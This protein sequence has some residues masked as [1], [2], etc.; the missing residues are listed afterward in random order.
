MENV[1]LGQFYD[2]RLFARFIYENNGHGIRSQCLT[3]KRLSPFTLGDAPVAR[4]LN[5]L[6]AQFP[7][8]NTRETLLRDLRPAR[9]TLPSPTPPPP[10]PTIQIPL[11]PQ[12]LSQ[13]K[14]NPNSTTHP[15][16]PN[17]LPNYAL[18]DQTL[19]KRNW[20]AA[21]DAYLPTYLLRCAAR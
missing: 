10:C 5:S 2:R 20:T 9:T 1:L 4:N 19:H 6:G 21:P 14:S 15:P 16:I 3:R 13:P 12:P 8:P 11:P 7:F 18:H 17:E